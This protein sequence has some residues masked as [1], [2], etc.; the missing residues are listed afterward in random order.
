M[1]PLSIRNAAGDGYNTALCYPVLDTYSG[2]S[3]A[4]AQWRS[5]AVA[6]WR[7][8]AVAQWRSGAVAQWRSGAVAQWLEFQVLD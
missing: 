4:V 7:S 5:G 3:G 1:A 8:G 2:D 6:Q